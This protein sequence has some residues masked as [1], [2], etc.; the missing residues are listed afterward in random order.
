MEKILIIGGN[1]YLGAGIVKFL[2]Q[3]KEF[4]LLVGSRNIPTKNASGITY[5]S[6][7]L[8]YNGVTVEQLATIVEGVD[9]IIH[10]ASLDDRMCRKHPVEANDVNVSGVIKMLQAAKMAQV[11][12]F[13]YFS[14]AHIYGSPL[15][16][17]LDENS[18][19][20]P[21]HEYAITHRSAEDYVYME[22]Q[23]GNIEAIILRLSNGFGAPED[24]MAH[25]WQLLVNDV[26]KQAVVNKEIKL[27]SSGEQYRD[28]ICKSDIGKAVYYFIRY[29]N[30]VGNPLI[31][32][33]SGIPFTII[34]MSRLVAKRATK[35]FGFEVSV[36]AMAKKEGEHYPSLEYCVDK[37]NSLGFV[38][39]N[40]FNL[41]I[42]KLLLFCSD[43][44]GGMIEG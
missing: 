33:G 10:L 3:T 7:D 40:D 1:G 14:T 37:L 39:E 35:L 24:V 12:R 13:I 6:L 20:R 44:F 25:C 42:D 16:G 11:K 27:K 8:S 19:P 17:R 41:E 34:D 28:F 18:Q 9:C 4:E 43:N 29:K 38:C 36:K 2:A 21:M 15:Q 23:L 32:L 5:Y 26:S 31:N 22:H 30:T